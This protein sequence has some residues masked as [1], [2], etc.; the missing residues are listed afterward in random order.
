MSERANEPKP[1]EMALLVGLRPG[2]LN[3]LPEEDRAAIPVM[4][5]RP[6]LLGL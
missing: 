1:G 6:L 4:V 5:G 2:F 3:D